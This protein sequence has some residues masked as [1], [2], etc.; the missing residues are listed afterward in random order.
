MRSEAFQRLFKEG[1]LSVDSKNQGL[2]S[3]HADFF[4]AYLLLSS[5]FE[6]PLARSAVEFDSRPDGLI[7][8]IHN[9][10]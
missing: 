4:I 5:E 1:R 10:K 2:S 9:I 8:E 3:G 6:Q 7:I